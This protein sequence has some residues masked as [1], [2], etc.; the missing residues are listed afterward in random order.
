MGTLDTDV[1]RI[2]EEFNNSTLNSLAPV[3]P[4]AALEM[5]ADG[6]ITRT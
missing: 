6:H 2:V 4:S 1:G 5:P 3:K